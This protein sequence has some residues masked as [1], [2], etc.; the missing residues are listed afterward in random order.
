MLGRSCPAPSGQRLPGWAMRVPQE[1]A[2]TKH[3]KN[4]NPGVIVPPYRV[5]CYFSHCW[6][7]QLFLHS[8]ARLVMNDSSCVEQGD[9]CH[10]RVEGHRYYG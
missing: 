4:S 1:A 3:S 5:F 8:I 2:R 10:S 6:H 9:R 7:G